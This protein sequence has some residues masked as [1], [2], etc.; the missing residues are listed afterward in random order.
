MIKSISLVPGELVSV[1]AECA[2]IRTIP[3]GALVLGHVINSSVDKDTIHL[4]GTCDCG[5]YCSLS[6]TWD[7][8]AG[9]PPSARVAGS[10]FDMQRRAINT[11]AQYLKAQGQI[12]PGCAAA[13][14]AEIGIPPDLCTLPIDLSSLVA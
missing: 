12:H 2:C 5:G 13:V 4:P 14:A 7:T 10:F 9:A 8:V 1:C 11:L 6:R 3:I